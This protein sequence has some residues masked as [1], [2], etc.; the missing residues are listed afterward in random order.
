MVHIHNSKEIFEDKLKFTGSV[1]Y[2]KKIR[3][4]MEIT[5]KVSFVYS[6]GERKIIL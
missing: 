1:R 3:F 6:A 5:L 2:D 4:L